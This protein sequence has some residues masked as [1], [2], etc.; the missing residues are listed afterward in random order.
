MLV[1]IRRSSITALFLA[2]LSSRDLQTQTQCA[3]NSNEQAE[4][5]YPFV[6][7]G[8]GK[9]GLTAA[10]EISKHLST[11]NQHGVKSQLLI[12]EPNAALHERIASTLSSS[13]RMAR[14]HLPVDITDRTVVDIDCS[15]KF[16]TLEGNG[17][18]RYG[19]CLIA[20]GAESSPY[21]SAYV[22][23]AQD[24]DNLIGC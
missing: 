21:S 17:R 19:K 18:I 13:S 11:T 7:I 22:D 12:I 20:I 14:G 2:G 24:K 4:A 23:S 5:E 6:I 1:R 8:C 16:L 10:Q 3:S 15:N 9:A